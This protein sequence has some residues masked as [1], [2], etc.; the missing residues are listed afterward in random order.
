MRPRKPFQKLSL[1]PFAQK[2]DFQQKTNAQINITCLTRKGKRGGEKQHAWSHILPLSNQISRLIQRLFAK[3]L[4]SDN[5][6]PRWN[7]FKKTTVENLVALPIENI[8]WPSCPTSRFETISLQNG[9]L[10][11]CTTDRHLTEWFNTW[12]TSRSSLA[13]PLSLSL[14]KTF[15]SSSLHRK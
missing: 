4:L 1:A 10:A 9:C 12:Q 7:S 11:T 3:S 14:V 13:N 2:S 5:Q 15:P 6:D 8:A